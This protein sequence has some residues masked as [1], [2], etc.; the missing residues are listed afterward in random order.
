MV[1]NLISILNASFEVRGKVY[2]GKYVTIKNYEK[3][4]AQLENNFIF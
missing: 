4:I 1:I 3:T 2:F